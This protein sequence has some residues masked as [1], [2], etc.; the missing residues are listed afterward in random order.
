MHRALYMKL[1]KCS[2]N[3]NVLFR[4]CIICIAS[5]NILK[6]AFCIKH[7]K[8]NPSKKILKKSQVL[9]HTILIKID[10]LCIK[11]GLKISR[12]GGAV[13]GW[14]SQLGVRPLISAQVMISG[15]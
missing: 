10:L 8:I 1:S 6:A 11:E 13:P 14:L 2:I 9:I 4:V 3:V 7:N 5:L 12:F 15:L